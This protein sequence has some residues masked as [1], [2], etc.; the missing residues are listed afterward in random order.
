M[1]IYKPQPYLYDHQLLTKMQLL[2]NST[3]VLLA[4]SHV[5][6]TK[7]CIDYIISRRECKIDLQPLHSLNSKPMKGKFLHRIDNGEK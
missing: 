5:M 6:L 4:T 1:C 2:P 3:V 7:V